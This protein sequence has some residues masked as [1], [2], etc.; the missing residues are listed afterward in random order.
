[1][2]SNQL[3]SLVPIFDGS[4]YGTWT[5]AMKAFLMSQ[6]YWGIVD[7]SITQ[8]ADADL[9]QEWTRLDL[10]A[11]GHITLCLS[12]SIQEYVERFDSSLDTWTQIRDRYGVASVPSIYKDFKEAIT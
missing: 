6:G 11:K 1:M 4:N 9:A 12:P 10:M 2:S 7:G 3:T 5:K 8:P